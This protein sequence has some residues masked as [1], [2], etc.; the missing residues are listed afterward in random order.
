MKR[1]VPTGVVIVVI[2]VAL[3]IIGLFYYRSQGGETPQPTPQNIRELPAG[4]PA[5]MPRAP[6]RMPVPGR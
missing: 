3:V 6:M 1:E 4:E 2:V 5:G